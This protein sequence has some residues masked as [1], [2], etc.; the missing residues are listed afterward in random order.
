MSPEPAR[1]GAPVWRWRSDTTLVTGKVIT[2]YYYRDDKYPGESESH[3]PSEP[4]LW[5][6]TT[7]EA[8]AELRDVMVAAMRAKAPT[9][10]YEIAYADAVLR[11][12]G[13]T[14]A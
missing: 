13:F 14:D 9:G 1:M 11:A 5:F 12:M 2:D 4:G 6:A 8:V 10:G 7:P 3:Y